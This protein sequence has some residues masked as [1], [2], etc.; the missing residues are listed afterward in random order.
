MKKKKEHITTKKNESDDGQE[1]RRIKGHL[2][3]PAGSLPFL[4]S[5]F[6]S[7]CVCVKDEFRLIRPIITTRQHAHINKQIQKAR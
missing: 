4:S 2:A 5:P 6:F 3:K 7:S 1:G